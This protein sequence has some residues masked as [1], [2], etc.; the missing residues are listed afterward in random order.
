V[1]GLVPSPASGPVRIGRLTVSAGTGDGEVRSTGR[2]IVNA[3]RGLET[4]SGSVLARVPEP[5][6]MASF[7]AGILGLHALARHRRRG[8]SRA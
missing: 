5:G 7:V 6:A 1:N 4:V 8:G 3:A 2:Q